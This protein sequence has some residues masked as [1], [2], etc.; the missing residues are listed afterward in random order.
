MEVYRINPLKDPR[1]AALVAR[2][3]QASVFHSTG[4]IEALHR[5]YGYEP[6]AYTTSPSGRELADG[7]PFCRIRTWL[8]G[9]RLVSLPFSDHCEPL[10]E[11]EENFRAL[12]DAVQR[13]LES[14]KWKYAEIR[15]NALACSVGPELSNSEAFALH[16]LDLRPGLRALFGGLH[17]TCVQRKIQ[18]AEREGLSCA[19]GNSESLLQKFYS[20]L[21]QTRRRHGLP[22]QPVQW[23]RNLIACLGERVRIR[24]ASKNDFPVA[25]IL[26]LVHGKTLV[27]KYGCSDERFNKLGGTQL[28][29]WKAI[30]DACADGLIAFDLGRSELDN[31]GLVRFKDRWGATRSTLHYYRCSLKPA[32]L[33]ARAWPLNLARFCFSRIPNPFLAAAGRVLYRH[34]G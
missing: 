25:A 6:V 24:I 13:D 28:L 33:V 1:W 31:T 17:K 2:H 11:S 26:T 23:F 10:I 32:L 8:T 27:Y 14:E 15:P 3:P 21:L 34:I 19:E 16:T 18:R 22:P 7:I 4:W 9:P 29:F 12:L 5:T 20:L 30:E